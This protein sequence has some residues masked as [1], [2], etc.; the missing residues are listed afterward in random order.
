MSVCQYF[1]KQNNTL[2]AANRKRY[3]KMNFQNNTVTFK[4]NASYCEQVL[5]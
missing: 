3:F 4:P 5:K 1:F 2:S